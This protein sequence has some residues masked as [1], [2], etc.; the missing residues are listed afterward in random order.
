M[1]NVSPEEYEKRTGLSKGAYERQLFAR[2]REHLLVGDAA[3]FLRKCGASF[4][5]VNLRGEGA[6][7]SLVVLFR[8]GK[9][10]DRVFGR[11]PA[12]LARSGPG[13]FPR[14]NA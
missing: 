13:R 12:D 9:T 4:D 14:R 6:E 3:E 2:A 1:T 11:A 7:T 10:P 5:E 8:L